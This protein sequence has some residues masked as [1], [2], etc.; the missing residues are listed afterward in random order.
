MSDALKHE[1]GIAMV[2]LLKPLEYYKEKYGTAFYGV[3]KMY[4]MMEKQ[5]NRG[6]DGAGFASIKLD[7]NPG[8][9]YISR[10]RSNAQ[11]P[12]QDIFAQINDRINLEFKTHPALKD[13]VAAQKKYIPY[14]GELFLGHVRY[15]TFGIN[16]VENVHPFL[17]QNNWMHRN[18]IIAGNFNMTNTT[19]LFD[20]L[21]KLGMHPKEKADTIT[22]M[23][24][25]GHFLDDAVRKLYKK[26]KGKGMTKIEASPYIAEKLNLAKILRKSAKDW[27]GGYAMAG[28]LGH[29]DSFVL[30]DPAGIRPAYYYKDDEVIVIASERPAIQTV[31][32]VDFDAVK[33]VEPGHAIIIKKDGT[34]TSSQILEPLARKSCSFER[35][36]FSR[37][38]DAEIYQERKKLGRLVMPKVLE[39]INHDTE[40]TVFS[41]IPNTAETSF[42]GMLD[43]AQNELNK[44]KNEAILKEK[45]TL[46][47]ARLQQIQSHKIR[48][49]KIA[50]KDVK[51]RTFITE[52]SSRDDLVAHVYD[53][54][55][56]VVKPNDNLVII[57]DSIVRG[58]TLKKSILKML[59]RLHPKQI[60]VVSS[61]PQIRFPDCYGIDMARLEDLVAFQ[62]ALAL[63]EE[64]GTSAVV[65]DIYHRCKKQVELHDSEVVNHVKDL[66]APFSD[67]EISDKIA[68]IISDES[69]NADVKLIFQSV[70]DLHKACP[71]NLG[72]WYFT[73]DYPTAGGNRV[74]NR[75]YIHFYEGNP[76]RAY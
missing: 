13:D 52:D 64:R 25:I 61:A 67:Q 71:K 39:A 53:V 42:Y 38:S 17:R 65:E 76:E 15:G 43:A 26:A 32:N 37:G 1:C 54:T 34:M 2:R 31:F 46:T 41:F 36:Y 28:L 20:N 72:D 55:Y 62:A 50:I 33:E 6:Q 40:N 3:N 21:I 16:S 19:E 68:D 23:E 14:I 18:L 57:D 27:D 63:H 24:K 45:E 47:D 69:I 5:H 59:D 29:G 35:I 51:L 11:Q 60:V 73:G 12:I 70:A 66:Y 9:R 10:V 56:G 75:A 7:V 22:V 48:T 30:R 58:T 4:L 44:Q 8:E 74:V 49:E